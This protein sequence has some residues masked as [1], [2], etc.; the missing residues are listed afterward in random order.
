MR[1]SF[2]G[3]IDYNAQDAKIPGFRDIN[4]AKASGISM[5]LTCI[6]EK[7]NRA[8]MECTGFKNDS[9]KTFDTDNNKIE[10]S[11]ND[12]EDADIVKK[13]ASYRKN[14][15]TLNGER[16]EF[17]ATLD[18][19]QFV[20][21]HISEIK[22]KE[23][24]VTGQIQKNEYN[25]VISDRFII[26]NMFEVEED[27]KHQ[28]KVYGEFFFS[29]DSV[30]LSDWKNDKKIIFN[31]YTQE[32][33]S[34][35]HPKAYV[36]R[37]L[38]FDCSKLN[39]ENEE[40]LRILELRLN[41][42]GLTYNKDTDKIKVDLKKNTYYVQ[43]VILSYQNGAQAIDF[44]ESQLTPMQK[45]MIELGLKTVDDF[46]PAG[47]M[48][49]AKVKIMKLVDFDVRGKYESGFIPCDD[50][51]KEF[52]ENIYV[53]VKPESEDDLAGAMNPPEDKS[54]DDDID[55]LFG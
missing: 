8:F 27:K 47:Q 18:F 40:H 44:D 53:S 38:I 35:E 28:L 55:D 7:N 39:F 43:S 48:Y 6:A 26:Q 34:K 4:T 5:S 19:I 22:G 16:H 14:V 41:L 21:D 20:R 17:V 29:A 42:M 54:G 49:G 2:I 30:D 52:E 1:F 51:A 25:G 10:V 15:I 24:T 33:M 3:I 23:F 31:G 12:R 45:Q 46:R 50:T 13:V 36:E 32:Y 9:I 37:T 11:W